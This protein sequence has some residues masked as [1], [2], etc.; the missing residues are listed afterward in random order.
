[1]LKKEDGS[2]LLPKPTPEKE[3]GS[4]HL[5]EAMLKKEDGSNRDVWLY[6]VFEQELIIALGQYINNGNG[7]N[8]LYSFYTDF[9]EAVEQ[10]NGAALKMKEAEK[11]LTLEDTHLLPAEI[12][13]D[14][15]VIGRL[16]NALRKHFLKNA[17]WDLVRKTARELLHLHNHGKA[18]T[19]QLREVA[20]LSVSGIA[21]HLPKLQR[22]DLI[23]KHPPGNYAL[24]EKSI[25][26]LLETFGVAKSK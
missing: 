15:K 25:H 23:K 8:S 16:T 6:T 18:T 3:D 5:S 9:V 20:G 24:T 11:N 1:M 13:V 19:I 10:K 14:D 7:Q 4:N 17:P 12:T 2:N 22:A 21:K 26:I